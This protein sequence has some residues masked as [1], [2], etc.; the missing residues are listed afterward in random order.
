MSPYKN[1]YS[2]ARLKLVNI[3][4]KPQL[5]LSIFFQSKLRLITTG[6]AAGAESGEGV[7]LDWQGEVKAQQRPSEVS[8]KASI[9]EVKSFSQDNKLTE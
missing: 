8:E 9:G 5:Y 7:V 4:T 6:G 3:I 1:S 2:T